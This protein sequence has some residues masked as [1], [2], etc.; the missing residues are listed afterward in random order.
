MGTSATPVRE[1]LRRLQS[2]GLVE[3]S[4]A[5]TAVVRGLAVDDIRDLYQVRALL[6]QWA[7]RESVPLFDKEGIAVLE[8]NV[9]EAENALE[10]GDL[11]AFSRRNNEFHIELCRRSENRYLTK[12]L[13]SI[14][15]QLH[16]VRVALAK[17]T[18][19]LARATSDNALKTHWDIIRAVRV[20]DAELAADLVYEDV[21][22]LLEDIEAGRLDSLQMILSPG[23]ANKRTASDIG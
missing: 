15:D 10:M 23:L 21:A 2:E 9:R 8:S 7:V 5:R 22:E 4:Y 12:L 18:C 11:V 17:Q 14:A 16:R 6:E 20:G 1:A 3:T 19:E 13:D